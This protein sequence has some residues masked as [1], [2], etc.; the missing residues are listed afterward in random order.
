MRKK[1]A[2]KTR[3]EGK[4]RYFYQWFHPPLL[5]FVNLFVALNNF[6]PNVP[7]ELYR[8]NRDDFPKVFHAGGQV[9]SSTLAGKRRRADAQPSMG[10]RRQCGAMAE[11]ACETAIPALPSR[12]EHLA[13]APRRCTR[14]D[15][16]LFIPAKYVLYLSAQLS[17][18]PLPRASSAV[19]PVQS[20]QDFCRGLIPLRTAR[21]TT[22]KL[23]FF[24]RSIKLRY[25]CNPKPEKGF[26]LN[27][28][29]KAGFPSVNQQKS[30]LIWKIR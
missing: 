16:I 19:I 30:R 24:A 10:L 23:N 6:S 18:S 11:R 4:N 5:T 15:V 3:L 29:R 1:I 12:R 13:I 2:G 27:G 25:L 22:K 21:F 8:Q 7:K 14:M 26:W 9:L 17:I 28:K 20:A